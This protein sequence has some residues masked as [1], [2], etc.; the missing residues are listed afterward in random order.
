MFWKKVEGLA[1][2]PVSSKVALTLF[3]CIAGL[4]YIFGFFNI[5]LSY[6]RMDGKPGFSIEDIQLAFSGSGGV[7]TLEKAVD[8]PMK[9]NFASDEEYSKMKAWLKAGAK[10]ADF[11]SVKGIFDNSCVSCH[12]TDAKMGGVALENYSEVSAVLQKDSGMSVPRLV[13]L[14]HLHV[15][16]ILSLVF[17][18]CLVFSFT[19]FAEPVKILVMAFSLCSIV[20]DIG[21]WWLAKFVAA[22]APLVILGGVCLAISFLALILLL[23]YD[24]WLRKVA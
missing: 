13:T 7:T 14:S 6:S 15:M 10:E 4:G 17:L 16:G 11:A 19:A 21:S 18:L 2:L 23:L 8:G 24:L 5:Y 12:S 1:P 20:A 3:L 9:G 22:M